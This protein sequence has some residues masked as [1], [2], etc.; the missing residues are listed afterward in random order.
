MMVAENAKCPTHGALW[1]WPNRYYLCG[2]MMTRIRY[3]VRMEMLKKEYDAM[4][5]Y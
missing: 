2:C 4:R 5:P 3:E 1:A